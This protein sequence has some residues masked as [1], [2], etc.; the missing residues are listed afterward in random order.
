MIHYS[1]DHYTKYD[2]KEKIKYLFIGN[3]EAI[4]SLIANYAIENDMLGREILTGKSIVIY[5]KPREERQRR[6]DIQV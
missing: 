5:R 4:Y 2:L 3:Y 6:K 1:D